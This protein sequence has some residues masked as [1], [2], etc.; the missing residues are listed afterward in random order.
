[1]GQTKINI[2]G[3]WLGHFEYGPEYDDLY[4]EKVLFSLVLESKGDGQ[5]MGKGYDLEGI[6]I[7]PGPSTINGFLDGNLIHFVKEYPI[8]FSVNQ[9]GSLLEEKFSMKPILTYDGEY[10]ERTGIFTGTW[11]IEVNLGP[12]I[13]GD[14][15]EFSTGKWEMTRA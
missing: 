4:G 6:G 8:H 9:D 7:Q 1:M 5:F 10:N 12:T 11:E 15:L 13:H 2:S 3:Q 14:L